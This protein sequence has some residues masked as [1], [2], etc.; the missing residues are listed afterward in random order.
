MNKQKP[1]ISDAAVQV[2]RDEVTA[3]KVQGAIEGLSLGL[4]KR[5]IKAVGKNVPFVL[6]AFSGAKYH[7]TGTAP[8]EYAM[9]EMRRISESYY[10][11]KAARLKVDH[12]DHN[13]ADDNCPL[14]QQERAAHVVHDEHT[15]LADGKSNG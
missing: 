9:N 6:I 14:C 2:A 3:L 12:I 15:P 13:M 8:R 7:Y 5:F 4:H 11:A 1:D 10:A